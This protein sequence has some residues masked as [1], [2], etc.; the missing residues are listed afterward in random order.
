MATTYS[1]WEIPQRPGKAS[2]R[3]ESRRGE[4]WTCNIVFPARDWCLLTI[5]A[6]GSAPPNSAA[7]V[8]TVSG[9]CIWAATDIRGSIRIMLTERRSSQV[10]SRQRANLQCKV[11]KDVER[12]LRPSVWKFFGQRL[13]PKDITGKKQMKLY[14]NIKILNI[15]SNHIK[16]ILN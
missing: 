3:Q 2:K 6:A 11:R 9:I 1:R 12:N 8:A 14:L 13:R 10:A 16:K 15:S 4:R 5:D 7:V